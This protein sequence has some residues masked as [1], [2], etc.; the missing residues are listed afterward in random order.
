[1]KKIKAISLFSGGL[2]SILATRV[3]LDQDVEVT[4]LQFVTP[5]FNYDILKDVPAY[6]AEV[7]KKYGF[8]VIVEDI[9]EGYLKL[10]QKPVYGFGK[11]FNPCVDCK[12]FMLKRAKELMAE[13]GASFLITGEVLGQRPMSQRR[14][15]LNVIERDSDNKTAL[16]R[17]LSAKLMMETEAE[18]K[19]WV[20]RELLLDFSGR[21]RSQQM[22]LA[23]EYGIT[24][25]PAPA[26][27]CI[28]AD[29]ILSKRIKRL[30]QGE[31]TFSIEQVGVNDIE[32]MLVGRQ[33]LVP[34]TLFNDESE[35]SYWVIIGRDESENRRLESL[36][37]SED[38][39]FYMEDRPGP[40][41]LARR[42]LQDDVSIDKNVIDLTASLVVRYGRKIDGCWPPAE[43]SYEVAGKK[44]KVTVSAPDTEAFRD[45]VF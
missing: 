3:I 17:P 25:Y 32:L 44:N 21:G 45:W 19:G 7:K 1:M 33:M 18:L 30:Y 14:D 34:A 15:T 24:D 28:L 5:F 37:G 2:D 23:K 38:I 31:F 11:N 13:L 22:A 42:V 8:N 27:G 20:N 10:L 35:G 40:T 12:I 41:V 26:G 39:V 6:T 36:A 9:S 43:V 16:L 29:P 4:A